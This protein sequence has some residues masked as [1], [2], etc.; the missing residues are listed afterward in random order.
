MLP[1]RSPRRRAALA[2]IAT[3][4]AAQATLPA[5]EFDVRAYGATGDGRTLDTA[6]INRAIDAAAAAGGGSVVFPAGTYASY[7]I[8]LRSHVALVLGPGSTLLAAEPSADLATGYDAP[9]PN[10]GVDRYEDFGHS[11]W[12][13]SL[14]WGE[15]LVDIAITGPGR[16]YGLGLSRGTETGRRDLLPAERRAGAAPALD[17]PAAVRAA[18]AA[19]PR[20]PFGYPGEDT[21]P[22][23]VGNKAIALKRCRNVIFRDFTIEHGGHFG[24]L[25][26]AVDNW[27]VDNLKIDTNRDGIDFDCC[28]NIRVANC[29]VNSPY[30]DGICPKSSFG[31]GYARVTENVTIVNCQVS[32]Y[33]EGTLLDGTRRRTLPSFE[34][35]GPTGR[36]KCG[37]ESNGG[38]RNLTIANC[39]FEYCRGLALESVDG[40]LMEDITVTN[41]TMRDLTNP[42]IYI[43]LGGRLRGPAGTQVGTAR[44]ITIANVVAHHVAADS[45]ILIMG[46]PDHPI[47]DL[48]LSH[49]LVDYVGGGSAA[50][51]ARVV[52]EQA[53]DYPEPW[54]HGIIPAWGLW[55]R[56]VKNLAVDHIDLRTERPDLR[57]AV[58]LD[59]VGEARFDTC[60]LPPGTTA[61]AFVLRRVA[62]FALRGSPGFA[63]VLRPYS[64]DERLAAPA[65]PVYP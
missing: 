27:T 38:F 43:R 61:P 62:G 8:H 20:G 28:Q 9:E 25:A 4:L 24:I 54:R 57:A 36:I 47:E 22:S 39:V 26:T 2:L 45:G 63:D 40:A 11:H 65:V 23:G 33:D 12:H 53:D 48:T 13:N 18:I 50:A 29:T 59:D 17:W 3:G 31:L 60:R 64:A 32:G 15:D 49:I 58:I 56:H 1:T 14:I 41:L 10:P 21:L 46:L 51:G 42:P 55:A 34:Y 37:T 6:A 44:R 16:I 7:S 5:A 19:A 52:P 35:G 30:D